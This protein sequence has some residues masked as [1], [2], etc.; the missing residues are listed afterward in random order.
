MKALKLFL[1]SFV[2]LLFTFNAQASDRSAQDEISRE[3]SSEL[4]GFTE[5]YDITNRDDKVNF[6]IVMP[7]VEKSDILD[8]KIASVISPEVDIIRA[9]GQ[10]IPI[11]SNVSI[12][13]QS[14]RYLFF[15]ITLDKPEF[16]LFNT[17][18]YKQLGVLEGI[19]PF[20]KVVD[21]FRAG[22]PLFSLVNDFDFKSFSLSEK[23]NTIEASEEISLLVGESQIKE[24]T[25]FLL[26]QEVPEGY[27]ALGLTFNHVIKE[28]STP[29]SEDLGYFATDL[30]TIETGETYELASTP[31]TT[32]VL[33]MIPKE[34]FD[35]F[36]S[37]RINP[38][39]FTLAWNK[40]SSESLLPL[41]KDDVEVSRELISIN[42]EMINSAAKVLGYKLSVLRKA[43]DE[44]GEETGDYVKDFE[45]TGLGNLPVSLNVEGQLESAARVRLDVFASDE[46][47]E[48]ESVSQASTLEEVRRQATLV[49]RY[50]IDFK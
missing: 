47:N 26:S 37:S 1:Y 48:E 38:L 41:L 9:A 5:G 40:S 21:A 17:Q 14:E 22:R 29:E 36:E 16:S 50:E 18:T 35:S 6:G 44:D 19:F 7:V 45:I 46:R 20:K 2:L 31:E 34:S 11:P 28:S 49:S 25:E 15:N 4:N 23:L 24:K 32:P 33:V 39:P 3:G 12:P 10:S 42:P 8:F 30:K 27:V 43:I 13:R